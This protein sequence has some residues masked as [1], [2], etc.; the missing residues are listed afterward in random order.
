[1]DDDYIDKYDIIRTDYTDIAEWFFAIQLENILP[2]AKSL[3]VHALQ[4]G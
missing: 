3:V 2:C 1:M 4:T